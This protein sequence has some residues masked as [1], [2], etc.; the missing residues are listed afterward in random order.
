MKVESRWR[1][2]FKSEETVRNV[3]PGQERWTGQLLRSA[4]DGQPEPA[5]QRLLSTD[6]TDERDIACE[7]DRSCQFPLLT[8]RRHRHRGRT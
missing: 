4:R 6:R 8:L 7:M 3:L 2:G 5:L 1:R